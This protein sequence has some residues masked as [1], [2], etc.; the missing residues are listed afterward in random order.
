MSMILKTVLFGAAIAGSLAFSGAAQA[1]VILSSN[2]DSVVTPLPAGGGF[3]NVQTAD[4]WTA[5]TA[6]IEV[7]YNNVAGLAYSGSTL[8]EL[9]TTG[10]SGMFVTLDRGHYEISYF[11]SPRRNVAANSNGIALRDGT[12]QLDFVTGTTTGQTVWQQRIV[13]FFTLGG[14]LSF[15]AM[16]TSDGV[17][18]YLDDITLSSVAV[19]EPASWAMLIAGFGLIG[20]ASR[21]Q[22]RIR[23]NQL[24]RVLA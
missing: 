1:T 2:F 5:T 10:N 3:R 22:R 18:G 6:G 7:Q 15:N 13:P 14:P 20:A 24:V 16:G 21:R 4:G 8:V 19:P 12:R 23:A 9:D 11:Y 17:G